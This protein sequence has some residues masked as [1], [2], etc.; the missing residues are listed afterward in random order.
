MKFISVDLNRNEKYNFIR[1][2]NGRENNINEK[3]RNENN[4]QSKE[5]KKMDFFCFYLSSSRIKMF[6]KS[7]IHKKCFFFFLSKRINMK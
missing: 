1:R 3:K 5:K 7:L 4:L 2:N 6:N